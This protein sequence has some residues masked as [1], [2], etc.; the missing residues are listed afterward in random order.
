MK[1]KPVVFIKNKQ[2]SVVTT[3]PL[4]RLIKAA[5]AATL[6]Y[7][8][9][10]IGC[11]VSVT[12]VDNAAIHQ[13]NFDYR[14]VDRETD[15]LSFP[16]YEREELVSMTEPL[17]LGDIVISLEKAA[18]QAESYGHSMEREVAFLTVHSMLHL[19]GYDHELSS[20]E[21]T[22]MFRRQ[23]EVLAIMGLTR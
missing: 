11:E 22:D 12:L 7:E 18:E 16:L 19:L 14:Q 2:K 23:E 17:L 13:L 10:P 9:K 8:D 15:V 20:E 6:R 3:P 5:I 4:R 1:T 21:E